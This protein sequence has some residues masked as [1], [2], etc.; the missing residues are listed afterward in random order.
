[1]SEC[2][3]V[4]AIRSE[5]GEMIV[6]I[7]ALFLVPGTIAAIFDDR[8]RVKLAA[9]VSIYVGIIII[10]IGIGGLTAIREAIDF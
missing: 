8:T 2:W 3:K 6:V 10:L 5:G 1:M 4:V 9:W 7:G